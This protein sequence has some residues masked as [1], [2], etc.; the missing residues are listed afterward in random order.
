MLTVEKKNFLTSSEILK[1]FHDSGEAS[2][3][4]S[5]LFEV[6]PQTCSAL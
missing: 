3:P 5:F 1:C 2:F 4:T 6:I